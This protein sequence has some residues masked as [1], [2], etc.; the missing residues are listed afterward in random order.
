MCV[1]V[2][3]RGTHEGL[4]A[5]IIKV[6]GATWQRCR[7]HLMRNL[8]A[9]AGRQGRG[10]ASAFIAPAFAQE[11][12]Q[13]AKAQWRKVADQLRPKLPKLITFMHKAEADVLAYLEFPAAHRAKLHSTNRSPPT[14]I[15][16][17]VAASAPIRSSRSYACSAVIMERGRQSSNSARPRWG[18]RSLAQGRGGEGGAL[19]RRQD[20]HRRAVPRLHR[21]WW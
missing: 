14:A 10:V 20:G 2:P 3:Q 6:L 16:S 11:D 8:L 12:A 17:V 1:V 19:G 15:F 9:H 13:A 7:G 5:A 18:R 4:N 21:S